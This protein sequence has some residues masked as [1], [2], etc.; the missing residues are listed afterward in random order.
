MHLRADEEVRPR[1]CGGVLKFRHDSESKIRIVFHSREPNQAVGFR[2]KDAPAATETGAGK[3]MKLVP[4]VVYCKRAYLL[5]VLLTRWS[6]RMTM[7]C[8]P[9]VLTAN[10]APA[11]LLPALV[12]RYEEVFH[13]LFVAAVSTEPVPVTQLPT[14]PP[15]TLM[16]PVPS[17][18][19]G[20]LMVAALVVL[21]FHCAITVELPV[22]I[23]SAAF[24]LVA[25]PA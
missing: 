23:V 1:L 20:L 17:D 21:K 3:S 9:S 6:H 18:G 4:L 25:V 8:R 22:K 13:A 11:V 19:G 16:V 14:V 2:F 5:P 15:I 24:T 7:F 12:E 10:C